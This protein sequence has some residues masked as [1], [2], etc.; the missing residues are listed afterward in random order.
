[1]D[2]PIIL[3]PKY[4]RLGEGF[5]KQEQIQALRH[6]GRRTT[7][8]GYQSPASW[9]SDLIALRKLIILCFSCRAYFNPRRHGYRRHYMPDKSGRTD[10]YGL[11]GICNRCKAET[12]NAG[13]G[14]GYVPEET[15]NLN[16]IEPCAVR[17]FERG[18]HFALSTWNFIQRMRQ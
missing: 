1:M 16:C 10:G 6:P 4:H 14:T 11:N 12:V 17:R 2:S 3:V 5:S 9:L 8:H 7:P 13:G 15:Y 18:K